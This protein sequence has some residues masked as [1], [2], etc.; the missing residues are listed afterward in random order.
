[1]KNFLVPRRRRDPF[2][3]DF[4]FGR[5]FEDFFRM[6]FK[7][8]LATEA[9]PAVDIYEKDNKVIARIEIPGADPQDIKLTVDGNLLTIRGEKKEAR[10][11]KKENYYRAESAWGTFERTVELPADVKAEEAKATYKNGVLTAELPRAETQR[12]KEVKIQVD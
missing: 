12:R 11:I 9:V 10:E 6:P 8:G 7:L 4:D 3:A 1:M 2:L 5:L